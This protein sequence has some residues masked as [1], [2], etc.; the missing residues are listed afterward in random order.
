MIPSFNISGVLPPFVGADPGGPP[1]ASSPYATSM[2]EICAHL[3]TTPERANIL[4]GLIRLREAL[5]RL[6]FDR[7]FQW[8]DGSFCEDCETINGRAPRDIDIVTFIAR[9]E[10]LR[11]PHE[12]T[13]FTEANRHVFHPADAKRNYGCDARYVEINT[14][15]GNAIKQTAYWYGLFSH[16]RAT[17]LWKGMLQ[18]ELSEDDGPALGLINLTFPA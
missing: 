8:M 11:P 13:A 12:W 14:H 16:Q 15:A 5:R 9:P 7:G 17:F 6:G 1:A 10:R 18:V 3:C 2:V 4:R